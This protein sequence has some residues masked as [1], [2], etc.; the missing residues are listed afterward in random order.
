[1]DENPADGSGD[2]AKI[3]RFSRRSVIR[4]GSMAGVAAFG[5]AGALALGTGGARAQVSGAGL[6]AESA[7]VSTDD[8]TVT[9]VEMHDSEEGDNAGIDFSW[10]GFDQETVTVSYTLEARLTGNGDGTTTESSTAF[11]QMLSGSSDVT[12]TS[13]S[14]SLDWATALGA[15]SV[16]LLSHSEI[17]T[18]DFESPSDGENRVRE[19]EVRLTANA[20]HGS[21]VTVEDQQT[22]TAKLK[23][24]NIMGSG[25]TGGT[26]NTTMT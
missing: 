18:A 23:T 6:A 25:T 19:L 11:E 14:V 15:T 26:I 4:Y 8:G 1:M 17:T 2:E 5:G 3:G 24:N 20:D 21:D 12:G 9:S 10:E 13:G 7:S 16:S 22:A